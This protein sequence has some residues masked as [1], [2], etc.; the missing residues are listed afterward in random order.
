[1]AVDYKGVIQE[2]TDAAK[3]TY[4]GTLS[5]LQSFN[6]PAVIA[7][8]VASLAWAVVVVG[9][10]LYIITLFTFV[11]VGSTIITAVLQVIKQIRQDGASDFAEVTGEALGE[12]MAI[13]TKQVDFA[14]GKDPAASLQRAKQLGEVFLSMMQSQ[15]GQGGVQ[16]PEDGEAAAKALAGYGINFA[17]SNVFLSWLVELG[18]DGKL[19]DFDKLG[20][21]IASTVG[22]GRLTRRALQPLIRNAISHPY[23]RKMRAQYR[24]DVIAISEL[25]KAM[26]SGRMD[27]STARAY[28]AQHGFSDSMIAELIAQHTPRLQAHELVTAEAYGLQ[29]G[30]NALQAL[31]DEGIPDQV[32]AVRLAVL[33]DE[34]RTALKKTHIEEA[35]QLAKQ[36]FIDQPTFETILQNAILPD[37][38]AQ[39]YRDRL[40]LWLESERRRL[41][42]LDVLFLY[43][44]GQFTLAELDDWMQQEG[45]N[46]Q[47][48]L[49]LTLE[50]LQ[51][52]NDFADKVAAA[53]ARKAKKPATKTTGP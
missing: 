53:A 18:T 36:R 34:R 41:S 19:G 8:A 2:A 11:S 38:E 35:L 21:D 50:F 5:A 20:E 13:D 33:R 30:D 51:K 27:D 48:Q 28:M 25:I 3:F 46:D 39:V 43:E 22:L 17:T 4:N 45:Y 37:D 1:M 9:R 31:R 26:L 29:S 42:K 49:A 6:V 23:D 40:G 44:H 24:P 47:D 10:A 32:A 12:F 52:K 15:F 16:T 14:T 7:V